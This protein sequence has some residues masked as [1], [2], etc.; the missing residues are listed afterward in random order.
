MNLA[1]FVTNLMASTLK[2]AMLTDYQSL[3]QNV[4]ARMLR[5][6]LNQ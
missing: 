3:W 4:E 1:A 5:L 6:A 2:A